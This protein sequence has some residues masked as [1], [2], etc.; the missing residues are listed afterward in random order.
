MH[1][2][3][4][5]SSM[6]LHR[7]RTICLKRDRDL[8]PVSIEGL[9]DR[10]V[11]DLPHQMMQ[12]AGIGRADIHARTFA[13]SLQPFQDL[14]AARIILLRHTSTSLFKI[15]PTHYSKKVFFWHTK[16]AKAFNRKNY[17]F[18]LDG[19]DAK[20]RTEMTMLMK[21]VISWTISFHCRRSPVR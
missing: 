12:T 2:D 13:D 8:I 15:R 11:H 14:N 10:V 7:D 19:I 3:R 9:V 21:G 18:F 17:R 4:H 16:S 5:S 6:I 1:A 20:I